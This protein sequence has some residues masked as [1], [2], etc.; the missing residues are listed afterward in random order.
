MADARTWV[1]VWS[2]EM[3]GGRGRLDLG[4]AL[5][6]GADY[7]TLTGS[8]VITGR[9]ETYSAV[10]KR[11]NG[12]ESEKACTRAAV[13]ASSVAVMKRRIVVVVMPGACVVVVGVG[14]GQLAWLA[15]RLLGWLRE[16]QAR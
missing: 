2:W 13:Q 9:E 15:M 12:E 4:R 6:H 7:R 8:W 14:S 10:E 5:A 16:L 1:L 3:C 11:T